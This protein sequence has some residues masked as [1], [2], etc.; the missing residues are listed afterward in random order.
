MKSNHLFLAILGTMFLST[1]GCLTPI[2]KESKEISGTE[3]ENRRKQI[4]EFFEKRQKRYDIAQ[5]TT[6]KS[7]QIIDW[8]KPENQVFGGTIAKPPAEQSAES[9]RSASEP[10]NPY[11]YGDFRPIDGE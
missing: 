1:L 6:T 11:L 2:I 5:T 7:G 3:Y 9:F 10:E 8:I 4:V